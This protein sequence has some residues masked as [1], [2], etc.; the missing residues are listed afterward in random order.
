MTDNRE[1][2]ND[3]RGCRVNEKEIL[4]SKYSSH[5]PCEPIN[6]ENFNAPKNLDLNLEDNI[7][8]FDFLNK[9]L[10][11]VVK[12][13]IDLANNEDIILRIYEKIVN[14]NSIT[15]VE[16][17]AYQ[18]A[19]YLLYQLINQRDL[20]RYVKSEQHL[21]QMID[22]KFYLF[23]G[24]DGFERLLNQSTLD[25]GGIIYVIKCSIDISNLSNISDLIYIGRTWKS[26]FERFVEHV[27]DAITSYMENFTK[28]SRYLEYL[29]LEVLEHFLKSKYDSNFEGSVLDDFIIKNFSGKEEWQFNKLIEEVAD[30][31]YKTYFVMEII[32][33]H[34]NY[35]TTKNREVWQIKNF[36]HSVKGINLNGTLYPNGLNMVDFPTGGNYVSLPIYD[37]IFLISIGYIGPEINEMLQNEYNIKINFRQIYHHLVRFWKSWESIL[38]LFFKPTMQKLLESSFEWQV[39]A[40][41]LRRNRSY[42]RKKNFRKWFSNLNITQIRSAIKK[43]DFDWNNFEQIA[44]NIIE[45][46]NNDNLIKGVKKENWI[47]WFVKDIGLEAIATKLGYKDH[48]SFQKS[49]KKQGRYSIY[50]KN[51]ADTYNDAVRKY[52]KIRTIEILTDEDFIETLLES[53]LYWIYVN[54]FGFMEWK[55]LAESKPSQGIRNCTLF[56]ER[57]FNEEEISF[58]DLEKLNSSNII[59]DKKYSSLTKY[60]EF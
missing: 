31:L 40:K 42:R 52:R 25:Y 46:Q 2:N 19:S 45:I 16:T 55:D 6:N 27:Y 29:I 58:E 12:L 24:E 32:E 49:W 56:F 50:Q 37:I 60:L 4:G 18:I 28:P 14:K 38:E 30:F 15:E 8:E 48:N 33:I 11:E 35:E 3:K 54:E 10:K 44:N 23:K 21:Q 20:P 53:R 41:V 59:D 51:F 26:L 36:L 1:R 7:T 47:E 57:L 22:G 17:K 13:V 43:S 5:T 34:R 9:P 39:I